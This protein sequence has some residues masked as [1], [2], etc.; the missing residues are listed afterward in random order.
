MEETIRIIVVHPRKI[1]VKEVPN[2]LEA[3]QKL[4]GG[5]IEQFRAFSDND[6]ATL[7]NEEGYFLDLP[8]NHHFPGIVGTV[9]IVGVR[10]EDFCSV[11]PSKA[12]RLMCLFGG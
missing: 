11:S 9:L 8:D 10:G 7:C 2:T 5:N 6:I 12:K 4:V 1:E 3:L